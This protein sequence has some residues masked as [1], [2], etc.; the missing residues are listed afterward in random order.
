MERP[1]FEC[2]TTSENG[3]ASPAGPASAR[4]SNGSSNAL[5]CG[6]DLDDDPKVFDVDEKTQLDTGSLMEMIS[7][8]MLPMLKVRTVRGKPGRLSLRAW[9]VVFGLRGPRGRMIQCCVS[10]RS[11]PIPFPTSP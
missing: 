8:S 1:L 9:G 4:S 5:P 11:T 3:G 2:A 7:Q 10:P 6:E